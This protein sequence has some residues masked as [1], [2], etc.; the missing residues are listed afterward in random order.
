MFDPQRYFEQAEEA[1]AE[2]YN[3]GEI[4]ETE[5]RTEISELRHEYRAMADEA[6]QDAYENEMSRW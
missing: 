4:S 6:A 5:F 1:L 3:S 2:R